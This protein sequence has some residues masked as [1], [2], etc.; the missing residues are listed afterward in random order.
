MLNADGKLAA[1][2]TTIEYVA[3]LLCLPGPESETLT[4]NDEVPVA[5]GVPANTPPLE[6]ASPAGRLPDDT[7]QV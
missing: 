5:V 4:V 7:D 6:S 2:V 1:A 3:V